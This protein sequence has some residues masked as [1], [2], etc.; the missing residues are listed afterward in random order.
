[1]CYYP[2][3]SIANNNVYLPLC[4]VTSRLAVFVVSRVPSVS[5]ICTE[6]F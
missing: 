1:M 3:I 2:L 4:A 5:A 6:R